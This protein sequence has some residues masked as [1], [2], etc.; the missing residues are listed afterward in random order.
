MKKIYLSAVVAGTMTIMMASQAFAASN[1]SVTAKSSSKSVTIT[2]P[3][4]SYAEFT[5]NADNLFKG[6]S[7]ASD[8]SYTEDTLTVT[9]NSKAGVN[10]DVLLRLTLDS[11]PET[12]YSPL[13]YYS[14]II[15]DNSGNVVY[16]SEEEDLSDPSA[17]IKDMYMGQFNSQFTSDTVSYNVQ[18][19][20]SDAGK[21]MSKED[22]SELSLELV[23]QPLQLT[24]VD[25]GSTIIVAEESA[26]AASAENEPSAEAEA[27][28]T[29]APDETETA[30]TEA[31][32]EKSEKTI[33]VGE[34]KD[35]DGNVI[36]A[37]RYVMKGNAVVT[38]KDKNGTLKAEE[39]VIDGS[40]EGVEGVSQLILTL[41][42]GDVITITPLEGQT[43]APIS[44]ENTSVNTAT[45]A[46]AATASP[47]AAAS[48]KS[49]P[50][51]GDNG[52]AL[53]MLGGLMAVAAIGFGGLG[54]IKRRKTN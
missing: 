44:L 25:T 7:A 8:G 30:E 12:D 14:F 43:S 26:E 10:V 42:D 11:I 28:A 51:T 37:G 50:K 54:I 46:A 17:V 13:D 5:Q 31:P 38:V 6:L 49:S 39:T 41:E 1:C 35:K 16:S 4:G 15:S 19:K 29:A 27:D 48:D 9:S 2:Y 24:V 18:Y 36:T 52:M 21:S 47:T 3:S 53:G 40:V 33:V 32:E 22:I 34:S 20:V 45:K 23:A